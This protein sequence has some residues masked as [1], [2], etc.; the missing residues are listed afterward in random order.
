MNFL[1]RLVGGGCGD[2]APTAEKC[3]LTHSEAGSES[4]SEAGS[5]EGQYFVLCSD[6]S[7]A[8]SERLSGSELGLEA[9][10]REGQYFVLCSDWSEAGSI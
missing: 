4:G 3:I 10:S 8:G 6:W 9:G 7:E 5:Q 1:L 2:S